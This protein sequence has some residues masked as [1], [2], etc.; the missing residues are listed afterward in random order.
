MLTVSQNT[1]KYDV[2]EAFAGAT[3]KKHP[4]DWA[5]PHDTRERKRLARVKDTKQALSWKLAV[6]F[7]NRHGLL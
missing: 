7:D 3:V 1:V 4:P 6:R 5:N 2:R